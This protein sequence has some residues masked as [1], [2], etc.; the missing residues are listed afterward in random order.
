LT[1]ST[2][3]SWNISLTHFQLRE[4]ESAISAYVSFVYLVNHPSAHMHDREPP[5]NVILEIFIS[6]R[7]SSA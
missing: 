6:D 1:S 3:S 4:L 2:A 7:A 5:R